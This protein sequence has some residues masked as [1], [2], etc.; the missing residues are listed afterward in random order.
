M[1]QRTS[2]SSRQRQSEDERDRQTS[3]VTVA[4]RVVAGGNRDLQV[5]PCVEI[6]AR[7]WRNA[8]SVVVST[9]A[10]PLSLWELR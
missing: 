9:L 8:P 3:K 4:S 10:S 1:A 5:S 7:V 6:G 2:G